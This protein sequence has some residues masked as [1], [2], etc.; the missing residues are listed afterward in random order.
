M[1]IRAISKYIRISPKKARLVADVIR[2]LEV[3]SAISQLNFLSKRASKYIL[4]TL[5]S[6][7]ANAEH[8]FGLQKNNLYIK[9]ILINEGPALKRWKARAFG[10]AAPIKKRSSHIEVILEEI[11]PGKLKKMVPKITT[12]KS[13]VPL[14]GESGVA[15]AKKELQPPEEIKTKISESKPEIFDVRRKGKRRTMQHRDKLGLKKTG[16][17]LKRIFRRKAI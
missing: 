9:N 11:Q 5:N 14:K 10:R 8:N 15:V 17:V 2:G 16:G 3:N 7:I 12:Q 6:A 13:T 4:K 1:E